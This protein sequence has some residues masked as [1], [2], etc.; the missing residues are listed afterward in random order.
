MSF[1]VVAICL[2]ALILL[3]S[4]AR[5]N[6][7]LAFV[8]IAILMG[9]LSGMEIT[10]MVQSLQKGIGDLLGSLLIIICFGAMQ[11]KILV[12]TGAARRISE[13]LIQVF[14]VRHLQLALLL[15]GFLVGIPLYYGI[16]FVLLAPLAISLSVQNRLPAVWLAL[17]MLSVLSAMHGFLP[18]HPSPVALTEQ[19]GADLGMV[20]LLGFGVVIPSVF[21]AGYL[22]SSTLKNYIQIP[23]QTFANQS[24]S[25]AK[26]P[27]LANSLIA[28]FL[29][30]VL[31]S[32]RTVAQVWQVDLIWLNQ[33]LSI[34]GEPVI[35]MTIAL[36]YSILF[37]GLLNGMVM[38]KLM[39]HVASAVQDIA[40]IL[41]VIGASGGLKQVLMDS[42]LGNDIAAGLS[43]WEMHPLLLGF[44]I[45]ALIRLCIG[46][47]TVA[48]LT[49]SG[50]VLPL[51][52]GHS[53]NPNLMVLS[54]G[55]GS[56]MFSHVNDAG[57]WLYK[58]YFNLSIKDTFKTWTV[59]ETLLGLSGLLI[60]FLLDSII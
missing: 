12:E 53:V 52:A 40:M 59:M 11:G 4:I 54:I 28:S 15:T 26:M 29:P 58:E 45:A 27:S 5:L 25:D 3:I 19:L 47:A 38:S 46:S 16:G 23:L 1:F 13:G 22:F 31:I 9:I 34:V 33:L 42:G 48:G 41:L 35:A 8:L 17:P 21:L 30:V 37:L 50:I 51:I 6:A 32:L 20:L 44:I 24:V 7:F 36:L 10:A 18:P 49:A 57:F 43:R 2:V 14:G 39:E 55:A 56:L 60:V